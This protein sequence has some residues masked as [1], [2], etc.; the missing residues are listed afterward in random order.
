M[1]ISTTSTHSRHSSNSNFNMPTTGVR[2][3]PN[4]Y[5]SPTYEDDDMEGSVTHSRYSSTNNSNMPDTGARRG[6]KQ[7]IIPAY[8]DDD[9]DGL[10]QSLSSILSSL[11]LLTDTLT[12]PTTR[13]MIAAALMGTVS[14]P[15]HARVML[16]PR[17]CK[18]FHCTTSTQ[19]DC[20]SLS[21]TLCTTITSRRSN[22]RARDEDDADDVEMTVSIVKAHKICES[23]GRPRAKDYDELT[24]AVLPPAM[25]IFRSLVCMQEDGGFPEHSSEVS[26]ARAAWRKAC[27]EL[28]VKLE[29]MPE[30]LKMVCG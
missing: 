6:Q 26:F 30:L 15:M 19:F 5:T 1:R 16:L 4:Q 13:A 18:S 2:R 12:T 14:L 23:D 25:H 27:A 22:K 10:V 28:E 7:Y 20:L 29:M 21:I 17:I 11:T 3:A 9:M 24:Q 8:E